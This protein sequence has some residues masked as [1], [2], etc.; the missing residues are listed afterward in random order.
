MGKHADVIHERSLS[1]Q[2][3]LQIPPCGIFKR[4]FN[5]I[6]NLRHL[7]FNIWLQDCPT[8]LFYTWLAFKSSSSNFQFSP[9]PLLYHHTIII[10]LKSISSFIPYNFYFMLWTESDLKQFSWTF[11]WG[12]IRKFIWTFIQIFIQTF[13]WL[14]K[15]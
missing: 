2:M 3:L 9:I 12:S 7:I 10:C 14:Y 1:Q 15:H 11:R 5:L 6:F 13:I 8:A 4:F